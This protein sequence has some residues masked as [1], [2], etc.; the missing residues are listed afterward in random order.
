MLLREGDA[1]WLRLIAKTIYVSLRDRIGE[2]VVLLTLANAAP[3]LRSTLGGGEV[4]DA[5][6]DRLG[7][8]TGLAIHAGGRVLRLEPVG[9]RQRAHLQALVE[10]ASPAIHCSTWAP[11]PPD[12]PSSRVSSAR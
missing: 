7:V 3:A 11:N 6:G 4:A 1:S 9:Q 2:S 5:V 8:E 12:A 10:Q